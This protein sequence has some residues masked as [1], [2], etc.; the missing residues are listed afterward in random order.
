MTSKPNHIRTLTAFAAVL[1][2]LASCK[3]GHHYVRPDIDI[4][5]LC[6]AARDR[7]NNAGGSVMAGR[8]NGDLAVGV[9]TDD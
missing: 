7:I 2:M 3:I 8:V 1:L 6:D 5:F 9:W 4:P